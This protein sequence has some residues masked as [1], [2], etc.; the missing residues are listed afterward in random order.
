MEIC[1]EIKMTSIENILFACN[2]S[3]FDNIFIFFYS[4]LFCTLNWHIRKKCSFHAENNELIND[5]I[6]ND[7]QYQLN[8]LFKTIVWK[9]FFF[10]CTRHFFFSIACEKCFRHFFVS[11]E[12]VNMNFLV[13]CFLFLFFSCHFRTFSTS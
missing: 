9:L 8:L 11:F 10:L 6:I 5:S 12:I 3:D 13:D 2:Q 1:K 7:I 4:I